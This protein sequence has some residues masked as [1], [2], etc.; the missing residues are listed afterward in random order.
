MLEHFLPCW[1]QKPTFS[2]FFNPTHLKYF[3]LILPYPFKSVP[4]NCYCI[5]TEENWFLES[6][7]RLPQL[8]C[9][10]AVFWN[11]MNSGLGDALWLFRRCYAST[12]LTK[13]SPILMQF[14]K[15]Y[16]PSLSLGHCHKI[17]KRHDVNPLNFSLMH[18]ILTSLNKAESHVSNALS[19]IL[20][21]AFAKVKSSWRN[22]QKDVFSFA[23]SF[24]FF[25][26][27]SRIYKL[28][29]ESA[30]D[31]CTT[32]TDYF[33]SLYE[34]SSIQVIKQTR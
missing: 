6:F 33:I 7:I 3:Q 1:I 4:A 22:F 10:C 29:W 18:Y 8:V 2:H 11:W 21:I 5:R 15:C 9:C 16:L 32:Y 30:R 27:Q 13:S 12:T 24:H 31:V 20:L 17:D 14:S 28:S 34:L 23:F 25:K 19:S 26:R